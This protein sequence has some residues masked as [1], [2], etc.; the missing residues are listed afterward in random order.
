MNENREQELVD[1]CFSIVLTALDH[2]KYFENKSEDER[3]QWIA[4]KLRD[5]GFETERIGISWG[6]LKQ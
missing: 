6:I 4:E 1:F 2:Y 5:Y 3:A